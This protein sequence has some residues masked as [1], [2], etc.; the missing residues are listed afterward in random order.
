MKTFKICLAILILWSCGETRPEKTNSTETVATTTSVKIETP[1]EKTRNSTYLCKINGE[2]WGYTKASGIITMDKNKKP[3]AILTFKNQLDKG[4]EGIQIDYDLE[5]NLI[6]K[7]NINVKRINKEGQRITAFYL[8][9]PD[10]V[11]RHPDTY[12]SGNISFSKSDQASG[13]FEAY[14]ENAYKKE[15]LD[16]EYHFVKVTDCEF[17]GIGY[18]DLNKMIKSLSLDKNQ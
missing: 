2:N 1:T 15:Q 6:K 11:D 5:S 8:L 4:S 3:L 16:P 18:S 14:V 9:N 17:A 12:V 13:T 10:I 7:I